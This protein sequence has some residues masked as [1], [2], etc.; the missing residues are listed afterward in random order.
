MLRPRRV[1]PQ[2]FVAPRCGTRRRCFP[3]DARR[4]ARVARRSVSRFDVYLFREGAHPARSSGPAASARAR[5]AI[6]ESRAR[7]AILPVGTLL[8]PSSYTRASY[9]R[10]GPANA[11]TSPRAD[12]AEINASTYRVSRDRINLY[13]LLSALY[14]AIILR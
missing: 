3:A 12:V 9:A 14:S 1:N 8:S 2:R 7:R 6:Y 4:T 13:S 5:L 11:I 10:P